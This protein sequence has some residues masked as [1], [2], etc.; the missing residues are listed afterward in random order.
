VHCKLVAVSVL[1][2]LVNTGRVRRGRK[3]RSAYNLTRLLYVVN[4]DATKYMTYRQ[5]APCP[6][7]QPLSTGL[8]TSLGIELDRLSSL[9]QLTI[10]DKD[11]DFNLLKKVLRSPL[12]EGISAV[13]TNE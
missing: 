11:F 5:K 13:G 9:L 12:Y 6:L 4:Y 7:E 10:Y 2:Y 3:R 8:T 1:L